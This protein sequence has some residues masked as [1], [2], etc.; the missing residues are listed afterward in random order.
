MRII[1]GQAAGT[2]LKSPIEG[3]GIRPTMDRVKESLFASLNLEGAKI[4]D[5]F[6]CSGAL[7]LE[8]ASRGAEEI[9]TVELLPQNMKVIQENVDS[10][11]ALL[12]PKPTFHYLCDDVLQTPKRFSDYQPDIIFADPPYNP[13]QAQKGAEDLLLNEVF[14]EWGKY[15][16][17]CIEQSSKNPLSVECCKVWRI[18]KFQQF[19]SNFLYQLKLS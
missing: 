10:V 18:V 17:L 9:L 12:D 8:A 2:K 16:H 6:A 19:G 1:G 15:A 13:N 7:G 5:L 11:L 4:A 3:A 14:I